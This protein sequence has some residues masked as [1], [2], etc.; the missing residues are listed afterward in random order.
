M[1]ASV[2]SLPPPGGLG[3]TEVCSRGQSG[4]QGLGGWGGGI[5]ATGRDLLLQR[6]EVPSPT[7]QLDLQ[8]QGPHSLGNASSVL[9]TQ[10]FINTG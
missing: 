3:P 2:S 5:L 4:R 9:S 1:P 10:K 7:P 8:R 6:P